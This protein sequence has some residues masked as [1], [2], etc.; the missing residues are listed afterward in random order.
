[1]ED[2]LSVMCQ[3]SGILLLCSGK[4]ITLT[5]CNLF[6]YWYFESAFQAIHILFGD[7]HRILA[8]LSNS[9]VERISRRM[10]TQN[11]ETGK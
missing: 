8:L 10:V 6:V 4:I 7:F 1:M 2:C 9:F 3:R 5:Q 11:K